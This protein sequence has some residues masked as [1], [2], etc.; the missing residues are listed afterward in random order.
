MPW[1]DDISLLNDAHIDQARFL[2]V[3]QVTDSVLLAL[4]AARGL[5]GNL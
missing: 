4:A 2:N 5:T 3:S 1:S